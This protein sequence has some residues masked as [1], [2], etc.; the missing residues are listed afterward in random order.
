MIRNN[1]HTILA[2]TLKDLHLPSDN[3]I[4]S[5]PNNEDFGDYA[6]NI[7]L[8]L[9]KSEKKNPMELAQKIADAIEIGN[10]IEKVEVMKPGFI[11]IWIGQKKLTENLKKIAENTIAIS[12]VNKGKNI[13]VEYS[14][15]NIAKPF[16]VGHLRSTVIGDAI[17]NILESTGATIFR[18]NH[19]GDW[20]T[21]FGK[22]IYAIKTWGNE[23]KIKSAANPVKMLVDLYVK[24][25][26]EAEKNPDLEIEGR[27]W[28]KKL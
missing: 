27:K 2:S 19:L 14:S 16:T 18:D 15:P 6:T 8:Q 28:F 22:L 20:G 23:D 24:F 11:N 5:P 10:V 3:L 4:I 21:Q 17:A 7:A 13:I 25:H 12:N 1:I 9:A 26:T